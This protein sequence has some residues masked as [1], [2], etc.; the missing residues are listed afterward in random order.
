MYLINK[1]L[2]YIKIKLL[3]NEWLK[4][5]RGHDM[6]MIVVTLDCNTLSLPR[7]KEN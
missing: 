6:N 3:K 7:A 4:K 1:H 5:K 2:L